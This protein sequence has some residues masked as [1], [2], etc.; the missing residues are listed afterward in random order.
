M[1]NG[2]ELALKGL[3]Q[4]YKTHGRLDSI[5]TRL[6][7]PSVPK[8]DASRAFVLVK[9][10]VRWRRVLDRHINAFAKRPGNRIPDNLR[11]LSQILTYELLYD[12]NVPAYAAVNEAVNLANKRI[13]SKAAKF[14]NALGRRLS[15]A[16]NTKT[17]EKLP[18]PQ[19]ESFPDWMVQRWVRFYG[20]ENTARLCKNLNIGTGTI[21][22]RNV[23]MISETELLEQLIDTQLHLVPIAKSDRFYVVEGSPSELWN[24]PLFLN[25]SLSVQGRG[26]GAIVELLNPQPGETI[27]DVCAAPGTKTRYIA[28]RMNNTGIIHASDLSPKRI[29][30]AKSD[31]KRHP[32]NIIKWSVKDATKDEFPMAD[33]VLIDAPCS[34]TGVIGKHPDIKWRRRPN[35]TAKFREMQ[36]RILSHMIQFVKPG[37][38]LVYAT[39]SL[40]PEENWD[41][42]DAVLKLSDRIEVESPS[43][44]FPSRWIDE[45]GALNTRPVD[46]SIDGLFGVLLRIHS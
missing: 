11:A 15:G 36:I 30:R 3:I 46:E 1:T 43:D 12:E 29:D 8:I 18:L 25:G 33:A 28:E 4:F 26:S 40:E 24:H 31:G 7:N 37:G 2:R 5:F 45:R 17:S 14:I 21:I 19:K 13:S 38:R 22:R 42:V 34:G 44:Q 27:L 41:V 35:D 20:K 32:A 6:I 9:E 23:G 10:C 16:S 39:C